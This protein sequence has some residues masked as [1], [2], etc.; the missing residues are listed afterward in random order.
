M[1]MALSQ[2]QEWWD[3]IRLIRLQQRN[4]FG[5]DR[6]AEVPSLP[7]VVITAASQGHGLG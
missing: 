5:L 2:E 3:A 1:P 6:I 4:G 7:V